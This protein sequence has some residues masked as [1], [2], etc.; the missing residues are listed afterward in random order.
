MLETIREYEPLDL[1]YE[2]TEWDLRSTI[3]A[4]FSTSTLASAC[5][6]RAALPCGSL[7]DPQLRCSL[8]ELLRDLRPIEIAPQRRVCDVVVGSELPQR[9]A[10]RSAPNQPGIGNE[11]AQSTPTLHRKDSSPA[12]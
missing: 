8:L 7:L 5:R 3:S 6:R 4:Y 12:A 2:P 1:A 11:L 9:L 10:G